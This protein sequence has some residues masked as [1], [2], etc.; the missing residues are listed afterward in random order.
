MYLPPMASADCEAV[1]TSVV[2]TYSQQGK[3]KGRDVAAVHHIISLHACMF[4]VTTMS[5]WLLQSLGCG[6][7]PLVLHSRANTVQGLLPSTAF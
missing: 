3:S 4:V 5:G 1:H 6:A 2:H 7:H